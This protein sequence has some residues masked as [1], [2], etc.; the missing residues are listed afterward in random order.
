MYVKSI[1]CDSGLYTVGELGVQRISVEGSVGDVYF[2]SGN[3]K[4]VSDVKV[5]DASKTACNSR[6][7]YLRR[8]Y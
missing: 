8:I 4:T 6:R 5:T 3:I 7:A 1:K 2:T